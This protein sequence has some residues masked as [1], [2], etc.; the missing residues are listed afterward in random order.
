V[1]VSDSHYPP[2]TQFPQIHP[3]QPT[4]TST[5]PASAYLP[6]PFPISL[7]RPPLPRALS[8][9]TLHPSSN[10]SSNKFIGPVRILFN[11]PPTFQS[12]HWR[13]PTRCMQASAAAARAEEEDSEDR[14]RYASE[15][16]P[17][18]M[19]AATSR[20]DSFSSFVVAVLLRLNL[21][22]VS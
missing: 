16:L 7:I 22:F 13:C 21:H 20:Q 14:A 15:V 5:F 11:L 9:S 19:H 12:T 1:P 3:L 18:I 2:D 4:S 6:S 8:K 17:F 10:P